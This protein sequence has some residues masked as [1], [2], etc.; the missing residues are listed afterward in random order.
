MAKSTKPVAEIDLGFGVDADGRGVAYARS[1]SSVLRLPFRIAHRPALLD[2]AGAYGALVTV[3]R[4]LLKRGIDRAHF[5]VPDRQLVDEL[6]KRSQ[7]PDELALA[8]VRLRCALNALAHY[9]IEFGEC[10]ELMQRARAEVALN[11]AA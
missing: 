4:A 5:H 3:A 6:S 8:Y 11:L 9:E 7:T 10:E 2:R 1:G